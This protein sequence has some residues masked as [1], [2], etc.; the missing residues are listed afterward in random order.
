M[1]NTIKRKL[2]LTFTIKHH[3]VFI[4]L[5]VSF[6]LRK[7]GNLAKPVLT[8]AIKDDALSFKSES[9]FRNLATTATINQEWDE[10]T[11]DG[12]KCKVL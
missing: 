10:E 4:I 3:A 5:G 11:P 8:I 9:S 1:L 12:R 6:A 7:M 2:F